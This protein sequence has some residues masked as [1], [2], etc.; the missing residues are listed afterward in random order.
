MSA[1][2]RKE[3]RLLW[4][5]WAAAF[6]MA[7]SVWLIP[8]DQSAASNF[9]R[10]LVVIPF[11]VCPAMLVAMTLSSF[12]REITSNTFSNLLAQPVP[13]A[14]IWWTKT[15]LLAAAVGIVWAVWWFSLLQNF[16]FQRTPQEGIR[17]VF[18]IT[19]LF[20]V[21]AYSGGLWTVLL[22]RQV[23]AAF[24]FTLLLPAAMV[25]MINYLLQNQTDWINKALIVAFGVY[26][27]A[28]FL[29]A[30]WL[31]FRAQDVHWTG[32]ALALPGWRRKRSAVTKRETNRRRPWRALFI[33]EIQLHQSQLFIAGIM[34]LLHGCVL[35]TRKFSG[36]L[37]GH[38]ILEILLEGFWVLWF[39]MPLLVGCDAVAE[40]RKLGTLEAQL[41]LP[42]RRRTQFTIKFITTLLLSVLLGVVMPVLF[43]GGRILP[44]A[45]ATHTG[46][47]M[48][49]ILFGDFALYL[50][51]TIPF[52]LL[53]G[54]AVLTATISFYAST[55]ARSTVQ[56]LAPAVLGIII[57]WF[58]LLAGE[59][60]HAVFPFWRVWLGHIIGVP[61]MAPVL[62]GLMFWNFK[63]V[64]VGWSVWRR[65]LFVLMA[66]LAFVGTAA[67]TLYNRAWEFFTP[68]EQ[69]H[70]PA[71]PPAQTATL[72]SDGTTLIVQLA[73]GRVWKSHFIFFPMLFAPHASGGGYM[74]GTNWLSVDKCHSDFAGIQRD[75]SL[76]VLSPA[77][78]QWTRV[79]N[80]NDW[81]SVVGSHGPQ[82]FLLKTNGT[83]WSLGTNAFSWTK[84]AWPG[85]AAFAP[86]RLG[87]DSDWAEIF[88]SANRRAFFRKTDG[89]VW[90]TPAISLEEEKMELR[91][92]LTVQRAPYFDAY[93]T[94]TE[95]LGPI[96]FFSVGIRDD[97]TF[98]LAARTGW[99]PRPGDRGPRKTGMTG[100][101]I[102]LD[103]ETNWLAV[104]GNLDHVVTLRS[105][106][107]LWKWT[108]PQYPKT[109]LNTVAAVQ[110]NKHSDWVAI[111][112][113]MDGLISLAADG[114]LWF[115]QFERGR[116]HR[117][118]TPSLLR[119]SRRPQFVGNIF[120]PT[121]P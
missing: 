52:L 89:R 85:L 108:F 98:R 75:G 55:L 4:P 104:A 33:K 21:A 7:F 63:R 16:N 112:P 82:M 120:A 116:S 38:P 35:L 81:K 70:G 26:S 24:W 60:I 95:L 56:A 37:R 20:V 27:L 87:T 110:L 5:S 88:S 32:G 119:A 40:E 47:P 58:S 107:T 121:S 8:K 25:M 111:A 65:N 51:W 115:T 39:V 3:M 93:K 1:L 67:A 77:G 28:G 74:P 114:S 6:L 50:N 62:F 91:P 117:N 13:R 59:S 54:I 71:L 19:L 41:C 96:G 118:Q 43:E 14:R 80:E 83:L 23:A 92:G 22:F 78:P 29:F 42:V 46:M 10:M 105:D 103:S 11:L 64:L 61:V 30:R 36:D 72:K 84:Q 48:G 12:G 49:H 97:E 31:F 15:L 57:T 99:L 109:D 17:N 34:A 76:W 2:V 44:D 79:G 106:G 68:I 45:L 73:D 100:A 94:T 113:G 69:A 66:S 9:E 90:I 18:V 102:P 53:A 101:D 86:Q